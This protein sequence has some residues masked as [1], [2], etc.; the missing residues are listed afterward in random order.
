VKRPADDDHLWSFQRADRELQFDLPTP[1]GLPP[2]LLEVTMANGLRRMTLT[3]PRPYL[4]SPPARR[5]GSGQLRLPFEDVRNRQRR[6]CR[7]YERATSASNPS[8]GAAG[9]SFGVLLR[10]LSAFVIGH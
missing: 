7:K 1:G 9:M 2:F 3:R 4:A 6:P 8:P 5:S 10:A